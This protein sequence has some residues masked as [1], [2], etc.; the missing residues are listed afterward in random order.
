MVLC[1]LLEK[2]QGSRVTSLPDFVVI[3][4]MEHGETAVVAS[5]RYVDRISLSPQ[6]LYEQRAAICTAAASTPCSPF[7]LFS[8]P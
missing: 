8:D 5:G 1:V 6:P 7:L 3:R 2:A 4:V